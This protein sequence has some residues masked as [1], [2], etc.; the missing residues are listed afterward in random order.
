[1]LSHEENIRKENEIKYKK[2]KGT[3][4]TCNSMKEHERTY[5]NMKENKRKWKNVQENDQTERN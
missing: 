1:M 2:T 3:V 4:R 5:K